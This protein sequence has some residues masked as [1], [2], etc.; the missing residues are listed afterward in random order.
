MI[1]QFPLRLGDGSTLPATLTRWKGDPA[2]RV[3]LTAE[4]IREEASATDYFEAFAL[5]RERLAE[6]GVMPLCYAAGQGIWPS[7]MV[8]DMGQGLRAYRLA[9][10]QL[11]DIFEA[12]PEIEVTTPAMQRAYALEWLSREILPQEEPR[13]V[14]EYD[15]YLAPLWFLMAYPLGG[16]FRELAIKTDICEGLYGETFGIILGVAFGIGFAISGL[17]QSNVGGRIFASLTLAILAIGWL[18]FPVVSG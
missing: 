10:R 2:C 15:G 4:G 17:R 11:V 7:G 18:L 13:T 1:H 14:Y 12:A 8:R 6:R 5:V 3:V 9:D 16:L